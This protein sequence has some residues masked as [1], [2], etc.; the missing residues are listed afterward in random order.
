M[1]RKFIAAALTG[2]AIL[3]S[4]AAVFTWAIWCTNRQYAEKAAPLIYAAERFEK[5]QGRAAETEAELGWFPTEENNGP[6][7]RR[8]ETG[9]WEVYFATGFDEERV[10]ASALR[11]WINRP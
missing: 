8:T 1:K 6:F 11:R 5:T 7:Y 3:M 9:H 10:Y 4:A 2:T